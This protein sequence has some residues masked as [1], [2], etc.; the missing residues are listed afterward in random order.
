MG[1]WVDRLIGWVEWVTN[2]CLSDAARPTDA[3]QVR[4]KCNEG[5]EILGNRRADCP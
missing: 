4:S 1:G 5:A 3:D 2:S